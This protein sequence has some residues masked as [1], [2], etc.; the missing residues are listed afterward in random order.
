[1][2]ELN[3]FISTKRRI[4][5]IITFVLAVI[6]WALSIAALNDPWYHTVTKIDSGSSVFSTSS[7]YTSYW[8]LDHI[9]VKSCGGSCFYASSDIP[10][11]QEKVL[12]VISKYFNNN[13][14]FCQDLQSYQSI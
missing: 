1:M 5:L 8:Y 4:I 9:R 2:V 6:G 10:E 12:Q 3:D 11:S 14:K 13:T 7:E